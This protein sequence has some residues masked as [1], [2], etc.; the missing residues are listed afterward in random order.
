MKPQL[1]GAQKRVSAPSLCGSETVRTIQEELVAAI[2]GALEVAVEIAVR[3]VKAI[4][5]QATND[6][7]KELRRENEKLQRAEQMLADSVRIEERDSGVRRGEGAPH[8]SPCRPNANDPEITGE[9]ADH[10]C[11]APDLRDEYLN[12]QE[13][14]ADAALEQETE[15]NTGR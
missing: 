2:H 1:F 11:P 4:V 10:S 8:P 7:Y 14:P 5:A 9:P 15:H 6:I 13:L 12:G 3:Q